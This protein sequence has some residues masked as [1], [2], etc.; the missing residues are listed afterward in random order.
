MSEIQNEQIEIIQ[1]FITET[2]DML[3]QLEPII[4]E[5]GQDIRPV[6]CWEVIDC[7][8]DECSRHSKHVDLPCWLH[9]GYIETGDGTCV[10]TDSK[11][12][13]LACE[14]FQSH[15]GD[16]E[17]INAIFR[18]FHS[19]KGSAGFLELEHITKVA[20]SAENLLD[21][22]RNGGVLFDK[23]HVTELCEACDFTK[24]ALDYLEDNF[25]DDGMD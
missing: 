4:I 20:H 25:A 21:L 13:C 5:L 17:T 11:N 6:E 23:S 8:A 18:L 1:E 15:N 22:I 14:V 10:V 24:D 2:R 12:D 9:L 7:G 3:E 16:P 19:M